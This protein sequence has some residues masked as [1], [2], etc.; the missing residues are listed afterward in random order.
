MPFYCAFFSLRIQP[1][2]AS[3]MVTRWLPLLQLSHVDMIASWKKLVFLGIFISVRKFFLEE[4]TPADLTVLE[5]GWHKWLWGRCPKVATA[6]HHHLP[7]LIPSHST[8]AGTPQGL[9]DYYSA[10]FSVNS[11]PVWS[12]PGPCLWMPIYVTVIINKH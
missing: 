9:A 3:I 1:L 6:E 12:Q 7:A 10:L 4:K 8:L 5:E 2:L 11:L